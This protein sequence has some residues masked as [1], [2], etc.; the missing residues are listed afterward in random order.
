MRK[1]LTICG[2]YAS[3][4]GISLNATKS[5]M[6]S[7]FNTVKKYFNSTVDVAQ[8]RTASFLSELIVMRDEMDKLSCNSILSYLGLCDII[9][10]V[11]TR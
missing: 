7:S 8:L 4:Y 5:K 11:I 6:F 2:D 9:R 3:E 10:Y 1:L